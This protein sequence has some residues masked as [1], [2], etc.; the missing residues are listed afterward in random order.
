[1]KRLLLGAAVVLVAAGVAAAIFVHSREAK[2]VRGSSTEEFVPKE[3][4]VV[5]PPEPGIAWPTF[6][7]DAERLRVAPANGLK[8][9]F[10]AVWRFRAGTLVEFPPVVAY[11]RLYFA[12]NAGVV[13]AI[14]AKT[15]RHAWSYARRRCQA[16][17][18]AVFEHLVY[19]TFLNRPPC[20]TKRKDVDGEIV[21]FRSKNGRVRWRRTIG[22][23]ES[24]PLVVNGRV[25]VG[26]WRGRVYAFDAKTGA[27]RWSFGTGGKIKG[28]VAIS[29]RRLYVGSYDHNVYAL[30]ARTGKL[31][32]K[33]GA[34]QRLGHRGTF[35]STPAA[36]YGRV[37]VGSTDGKVYSFGA[38]SGKLRWAQ[39]TGGFVYGSPAVWHERVYVGSYSGRF[40]CFDAATGDVKWSF[41]ANGP[42]SGSATILNGVVY[43]ATLKQRTYALDTRTGRELWQFSD[44]KYTPLVADDRR[45]YL[46]GYARIYG[47]VPR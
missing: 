40:L 11:G 41:K 30:N 14:S 23:T 35:Y 21:A 18:P 10:R 34:Q 29:G 19:V 43:F 37:Y 9:P 47:M 46:V 12:T 1:M 38:G 44:G 13:H 20:N 36:A 31:L 42:I 17:S 7:Y 16:A 8:P 2:D 45:V 33:A 24:S 26:D 3:P 6:G 25:Y 32:W 15:G 39:G 4:V 27:T 5:K 22:P 28:A